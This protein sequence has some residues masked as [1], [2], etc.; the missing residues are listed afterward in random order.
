MFFKKRD[1]SKL[2]HRFIHEGN[3]D[4]LSQ[5]YRDHYDLLL[6]F[7][8]RYTS[9]V[10]II[11]DSIQNIFSHFLTTRKNTEEINNMPAYLITVFSRQLF[12]NLRKQKNL[13]LHENFPEDY[14][15]YFIQSE[16]DGGYKEET[17]QLPSIIKQSIQELSKKQQKI[18]YLRYECDLSY[19]EISSMLGI[20]VDSCYK[21]IHRSMK[22]IHTAAKEFQEKKKGLFL[23]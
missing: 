22:K 10:Q 16:S 4:A 15:S 9:D 20:T 7:G 23:L 13:F 2:W 8:H 17:T 19:E 1:Y 6:N 5:I 21:L 14:F 18:I 12:L 3:Q 11:E